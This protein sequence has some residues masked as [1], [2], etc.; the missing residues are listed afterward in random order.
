MVEVYILNFK[1]KQFFS[2]NHLPSSG[3]GGGGVIV[4]HVK[5]NI[6]LDGGGKHL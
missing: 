3:G 6:V 4:A 1:Y 2:D 5:K